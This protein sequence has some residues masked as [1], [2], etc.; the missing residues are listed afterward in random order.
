[1]GRDTRK[2][3]SAAMPAGT[4]CLRWAPAFLL[5]SLPS[6]CLPPGRIASRP[7]ILYWCGVSR[8]LPL[9]SEGCHKSPVHCLPISLAGALPLGRISLMTWA[10]VP[11]SLPF[12]SLL[13]L[14]T[15]SSDCWASFLSVAGFEPCY[16]SCSRGQIGFLGDQTPGLANKTLPQ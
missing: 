15:L 3:Q 5:P 9:T 2:R 13:L 12:V 16:P 11:C 1:M 7:S 6:P 8:P 4:W 14:S 10:V